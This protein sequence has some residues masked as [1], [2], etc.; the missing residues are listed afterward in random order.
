MI[1]KMRT[2][3]ASIAAALLTGGIAA[4]TPPL[5]ADIQLTPI[6]ADV[7]WAPRPVRGDDSQYPPR[8]RIAAVQSDA[9]RYCR[10]EGR[11]PRRDRPRP[12]RDGQGHD[13]QAPLDRR[14]AR[15]GSDV[16]RGRAIRR[17]VRCMCPCASR[18]RAEEPEPSPLGSLS[19]SP[20]SRPARSRR[21]SAKAGWPSELCRSSARRSSATGYVAADGCCDS[22]RHVRALLPLERP[23]HP[24][25]ALR[26]RLGAARC[27]RT[28]WSSGD[29]RTV[30]SYT[31][32]GKDVIAVADGTVVVDA[33][34]PA[35][36]GPRRLP[37]GLPIDQADGNFVVLDIGHGAFAL[38][39]HMQPG[40]VTVA[41][42]RKGE[43]RRRAGQSRQHRQHPGASSSFPR[44]GRSLAARCRTAS[45]TSSTG[46]G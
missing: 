13:R 28:A 42:G 6:V 15:R 46:S 20:I 36:A 4:T 19:S 18:A 5:A 1:P 37:Q 38:F 12:A 45:P 39:A 32:F 21:P 35:G 33:Q 29:P 22:I 3:L 27:R 24:G 40:S 17:P 16:A 25:P 14:P 8:L 44:H 10:R 2:F 43:A 7:L 31:I 34:R 30:E 23:V 26:H 9:V 41:A 11:G